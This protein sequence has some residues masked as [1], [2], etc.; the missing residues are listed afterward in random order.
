[1]DSKHA[2]CII[3]ITAVFEPILTFIFTFK[4]VPNIGTMT[5]SI[6]LWRKCTHGQSQPPFSSTAY[7][8]CHQCYHR[9]ALFSPSIDFL[10]ENESSS[11]YAGLF[12]W[13]DFASFSS[14]YLKN[15][16]LVNFFP[17]YTECFVTSKNRAEVSERTRP[18]AGEYRRVSFNPCLMNSSAAIP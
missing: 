10:D 18:W 16:C 7:L 3:F 8:H 12:K 17:S 1:M 15:S 6:I 13:S 5:S 14:A 2:S 9:F 4:L 11:S